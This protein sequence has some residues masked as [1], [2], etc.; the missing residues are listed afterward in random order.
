ME[1]HNR[2]RCRVYFIVSLH[3]THP[4]PIYSTQKCLPQRHHCWKIS[5]FCCLSL[6]F[7]HLAFSWRLGKRG[8]LYLAQI[9]TSAIVV[10]W[11]TWFTYTLEDILHTEHK[12]MDA[13]MNS[14]Q[15]RRRDKWFKVLCF[16][17]FF[18]NRFRASSF[19]QHV[20]YDLVLYCFET[21]LVWDWGVKLHDDENSVSWIQKIHFVHNLSFALNP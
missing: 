15:G 19:F 21:A 11:A 6:W 18:F 16:F 20:D 8:L 17:F 4:Y 13:N 1:V 2:S 3:S 12:G 14:F 7:G 9:L 10:L 5:C